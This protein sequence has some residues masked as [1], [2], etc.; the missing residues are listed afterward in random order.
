MGFWDTVLGGTSTA[1]RHLTPRVAFIGGNAWSD[2]FVDDM[3][4]T[5]F[6]KTQPSLRTVV[7]FRCESVSQLGG[8]LYVRDAENSRER[9]YDS[10]AAKTLTYVDGQMTL[11]ELIYSLVGDLDL[12]D[13][14]YWWVTVN[15]EDGARAPYRIRRIPPAWVTEHERD[16]WKVK[17]W[18]VTL[19]GGSVV[20]P[21]SEM[22]AFP[23]FDPSVTRGA[24]PAVDTLR[25]TIREQLNAQ[26]YRRNLWMRGAK[27]SGFITRPA[28]TSWSDKARE[29]FR[30]DWYS[31]YAG[32]GPRV[33]GA[34]ILEDGMTFQKADFTAQEQQFVE[35][36]KLALQVICGVYHIDPSMV[37]M[38]ESATGRSVR[39]QRKKL[40]GDNLGPLMARIEDRL[41]TFLLP[42][43]GGLP[44]EYFEFNLMAKLA[45]DFIEQGQLLS[46]SVGGPW[47]TRNEARQR[48]NMPRIEGGDELIVPLNVVEGGQA[49]PQDS[50]TQNLDPNSDEPG[51]DVEKSRGLK[52]RSKSA[53]TRDGLQDEGEK[54]LR[55]FFHRQGSVIK[56]RLGAKA[57]WWDEKRW[58]DDL[59]EVLFKLHEGGTVAVATAELADF[60]PAYVQNYLRKAA[61]T[62]ATSINA[63]TLKALQEALAN[64][65]EDDDF[66]PQSAASDVFDEAEN[67]R[68]S[69]LAT[70]A[71]TFALGFGRQEAGRQGG[72]ATKTWV[73]GDNPRPEHDMMDGETVPLD[74]VFSN[75]AEVPG[76]IGDPDSYGCNCAMT[77]NYP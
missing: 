55:A 21:A 10:P 40:Y 43:I 13:R 22:L 12:Y 16:I 77:I 28:G 30:A 29:S 8:H 27:V 52:S 58:N 23:G 38:T 46:S 61:K 75:G 73:T 3:T 2:A 32:D 44:G 62:N 5:V 67:S 6:W 35:A 53:A 68:S 54:A 9:S 69:A 59:A 1:L 64:D 20:I 49:S 24:S 65:D 41:T 51:Q 47:M 66:D 37:G 19:P 45:G 60:D 7:A 42:M 33:G 17:S 63:N 76:G 57:S 11:T 14:A 31:N 26:K 74:D 15:T 48:Q 70:T 50:G 39:E 4:P 56:S 18:M 34:P 71:A 36:A 25:E 72:A